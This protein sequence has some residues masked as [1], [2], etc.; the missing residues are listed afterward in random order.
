MRTALFQ[1]NSNFSASYSLPNVIFLLFIL[2]AVRQ[3]GPRWFS[4]RSSIFTPCFWGIR[5]LMECRAGNTLYF[6]MELVGDQDICLHCPLFLIRCLSRWFLP[7]VTR[8]FRKNN[9]TTTFPKVCPNHSCALWSNLWGWPDGNVNYFR[10][11]T[12]SAHLIL[13]REFVI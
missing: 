13:F 1:Q 9:E 5:I 4:I 10:Q 12:F 6:Y 7:S 3:L 2:W 8:S 11:L